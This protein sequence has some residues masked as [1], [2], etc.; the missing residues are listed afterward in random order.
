[1]IRI[2]MLATQYTSDLRG[3]E[4]FRSPY[5]TFCPLCC[6]IYAQDTPQSKI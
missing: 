3:D 4:R 1:M 2:E 5:S 6:P